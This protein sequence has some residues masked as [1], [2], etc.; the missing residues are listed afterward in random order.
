MT[1][2]YM[3]SR[4]KVKIGLIGIDNT[5]H[6]RDIVAVNSS[7]LPETILSIQEEDSES[8]LPREYEWTVLEVT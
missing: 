6:A 4:E 5:A 2:Q 1:S 7:L 8:V 3:E